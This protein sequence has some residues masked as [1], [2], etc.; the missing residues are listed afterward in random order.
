MDGGRAGV[1]AV[2]GDFSTM[3]HTANLDDNADPWL[4]VNLGKEHK[5]VALKVYNRLD[6]KDFI[7]L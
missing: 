7:T 1:N 2:D 6:R 3:M 5:I 4:L